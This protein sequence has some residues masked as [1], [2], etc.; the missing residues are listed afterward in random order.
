ML[1]KSSPMFVEH[2]A[3]VDEANFHAR[4]HCMPWGYAWIGPGTINRK[5]VE[6]Y[7][8][9]KGHHLFNNNS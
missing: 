2:Y 8:K 5:R 4:A 3:R 9:H 7:H 6:S 1:P